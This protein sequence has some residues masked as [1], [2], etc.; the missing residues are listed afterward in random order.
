M[1]I[2]KDLNREIIETTV[3]S[4]KSRL[5]DEEKDLEVRY[6][7]PNKEYSAEI[8]TDEYKF[9]TKIRRKFTMFGYPFLFR[10]TIDVDSRQHN[11]DDK[12]Y[13]F[14]SFS[15]YVKMKR[16]IYNL[17]LKKYREDVFAENN[18]IDTSILEG[19]SKTVDQRF[20]R[21]DTIDKILEDA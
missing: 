14:G 11:H 20:K 8:R 3:N 21:E 16:W 10:L 2:K 15:K 6:Y 13:T 12:K 9:T 1:K 17:L 5:L 4:I 19:L 7:K 18:K